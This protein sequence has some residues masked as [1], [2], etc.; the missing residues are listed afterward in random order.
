MSH[1]LLAQ[2]EIVDRAE[3]ARRTNVERDEAILGGRGGRGVDG[4]S[5]SL[6]PFNQPD[7]HSQV[8]GMQVSG[9]T[10]INC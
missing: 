1:D 7:L 2:F 9:V 6:N 5:D 3:E 4:I 8:S 10:I